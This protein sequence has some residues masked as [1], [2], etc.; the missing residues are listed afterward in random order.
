MQDAPEQP[1]LPAD[2][3]QYALRRSVHMLNVMLASLT[4]CHMTYSNP[5]K[6]LW[7]SCE[8]GGARDSGGHEGLQLAALAR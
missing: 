3:L 5:P 7:Q 6:V 2:C 1:N 8:V 4:I